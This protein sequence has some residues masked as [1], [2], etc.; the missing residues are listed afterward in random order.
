M[1][2]LGYT[3]VLGLGVGDLF[4]TNDYFFYFLL[5]T[6]WLDNGVKLCS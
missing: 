2:I 5:I 3:V 6:S 4:V 1:S